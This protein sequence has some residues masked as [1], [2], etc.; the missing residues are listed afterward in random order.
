MP[1][2][3][4]TELAAL[5]AALAGEHAAVW[6]YG[7]LG[8]RAGSSSTEA[9]ART[10][11]AAHR[12]LRDGLAARIEALDADP[13]AAEPSYQLPFEVTDRKTARAL[14]I[15]LEERTADLY[16]DLV[17]AATTPALRAEA[18]SAL[19]GAELRRIQWGGTPFAFPGMPERRTP[20]R[21]TPPTSPPPTT[22]SR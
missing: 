17:A 21:P 20:P 1:T 18:A 12:D 13:V 22:P 4:E 6:G 5:Q 8:P 15:R 11:Y 16:G 3:A 9:L 10:T 2:E 19:A 7:V 14:A